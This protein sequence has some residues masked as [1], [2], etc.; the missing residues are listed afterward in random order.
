VLGTLI[1]INQRHI[2]FY[3]KDN[4]L[5]SVWENTETSSYFPPSIWYFLTYENK[6]KNEKSLAKLLVEKWILF[7]QVSKQE[8]KT[9]IK[10]NNLFFGNGGRY[11]AEQLKTR[12]DMLDQVESYVTLMKQDLK[13][14]S[15][16]IEKLRN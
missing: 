14:L 11:N 1:L 5:H 7:G 16:Q 15:Y 13:A 6:L 2:D 4:A 12:S 3:H 10:N 9:N 8:S